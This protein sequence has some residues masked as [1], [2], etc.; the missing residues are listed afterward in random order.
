MCAELQHGRC[1]Y[2]CFPG[3]RIKNCALIVGNIV[4]LFFLCC[5]CCCDSCFWFVARNVH[6]AEHTSFWGILG[7]VWWGH[8]QRL[9]SIVATVAFTWSFLCCM[10]ISF[11]Q[12]LSR[13]IIICIIICVILVDIILVYII[14][15]VLR[16]IGIVIVISI[17][18]ILVAL[19][20]W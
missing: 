14:I 19:L 12:S 16:V 2:C 17:V 9:Y 18:I 13:P 7:V 5:C 15:N 3:H 4:C 20:I 10:F 1:G 6:S 8:L 11:L